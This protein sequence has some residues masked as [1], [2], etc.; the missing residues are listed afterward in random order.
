MIESTGFLNT[1]IPNSQTGGGAGNYIPP[2]VP[3]QRACP[4][5]GYCPHCGR[6]GGY[7]P[8]PY[9][10]WQQ[11]YWFNRNE[12]WCGSQGQGG[13]TTVKG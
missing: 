11:P 5:C 1:S 3:Q 4:C 12:I 2:A 7:V 6:G 13:S 8:Q 10:Y 9:P